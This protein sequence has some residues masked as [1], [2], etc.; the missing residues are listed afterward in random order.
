MDLAVYMS[1]PAEEA[2]LVGKL[3]LWKRL[4]CASM[5]VRVRPPLEGAAPAISF[6][7]LDGE[8]PA[9]PRAGE[10]SALFV[11]SA[12]PGK[13][14]TS[15]ALHPTGFLLKPI[16]LLPLRRA[17]ERCVRLWWGDL[18]RTELHCGR[19]IVPLPLYD[20]I[21]AEGAKRGC[22]VHSSHQVLEA[23]ETLS[24]LEERLPEES[25]LRCQ[26]S[27]LVNLSHVWRVDG[28]GVH[29]SD[30]TVLPMGRGVRGAVERA[31]SRSWG[32]S[33][34]AGDRQRE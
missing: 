21:W 24:M 2:D 6:W 10:G 27:F 28:E 20:L 11:C 23:R 33:G 26:R 31:Y 32:L 30:G 29:L 15:Y 5:E 1:S 25:F 8:G 12:D 19:R 18:V 3:A 13:A 14:I 9:P 22:V 17:M 7:D 34:A 16:G 4:T